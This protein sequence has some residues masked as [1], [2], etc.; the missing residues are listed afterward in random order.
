MAEVRNNDVAPLK[1]ADQAF[2]VEI[3]SR[4]GDRAYL[5][6]C[7]FCFFDLFL[8]QRERIAWITNEDFLRLSHVDERID[9]DAQ[10]RPW[11]A[12]CVIA[13]GS[14]SA[15]PHRSGTPPRCT[16][17]SKWCA[18]RHHSGIQV[19][20]AGK[21]WSEPNSTGPG[22]GGTMVI[23]RALTGT[24]STTCRGKL[25]VQYRRRKKVGPFRFTV[26]QRGIS[27]SFG[28]GPLRISKGADGKI[29]R[30]IRIPG[31]GIYDT[32]VVNRPPRKHAS[33]RG[34][35]SVM[36][37]NQHQPPAGPPPAGWYR[38]P[39]GG[40]FRRYWDGHQWTP[41]TDEPPQ[42]SPNVAATTP[43]DEPESFP[44]PQWSHPGGQE[45]PNPVPPPPQGYPTY[46]GQPDPYPPPPQGYPRYPGQP[47]PYP[48]PPQGYPRYPGQPDHPYPVAGSGVEPEAP[49]GRD[50]ATGKPL[51]DKK[52]ATAGVLQ[53]FFGM[54]GAGRFYIGSKAIGGCQLGLTI[55]GIV[56]AQ[57]TASSDTASGLVG[58]LLVGVIIWAIIDAIRMF[59]KSVNDGQGRKLR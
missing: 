56:L 45:Q 59:I 16:H 53:L 44:G 2:N 40:A 7:C 24:G 5:W 26:S 25:M 13:P 34:A 52:A 57:V 41:A 15:L 8:C 4:V 32:K 48:P 3:G 17:M 51:S 38:D 18:R 6:L 47:D 14:A 55:L 27:T 49:Y 58:L 30:T 20:I 35:N 31:A 39:G 46:S 1:A 42:P 37:P 36:P 19:E 22:C 33:G 29:R 9:S 21:C 23:C 50:P 10:P 43:E 12:P 11:Q 54:F 28:A